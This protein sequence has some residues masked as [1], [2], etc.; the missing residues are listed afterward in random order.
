M[1]HLANNTLAYLGLPIVVWFMVWLILTYD[2]DIVPAF[3]I[4]IAIG[5]GSADLW[6]WFLRRLGWEWQYHG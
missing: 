5:H 2:L 3:V 4:G 6:L 1:R